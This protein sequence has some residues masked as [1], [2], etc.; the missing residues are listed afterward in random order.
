MRNYFTD[1]VHT[2]GLCS[3]LICCDLQM[4]F[5]GPLSAQEQMFI[6]YEVKMQCFQNLSNM[7]PAIAGTHCFA[8]FKNCKINHHNKKNEAIST[9]EKKTKQNMN[10]PNFA[11]DLMYTVGAHVNMMKMF[12]TLTFLCAKY[13]HFTYFAE[14]ENCK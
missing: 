8:V 4:G 14:A 13:T 7:E 9:E 5:D 12:Q 10:L 3:D 6:L 11:L 1:T 2:Q